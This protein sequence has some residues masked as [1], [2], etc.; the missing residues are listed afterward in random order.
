MRSRRGFTLVEL[1]VVILIVSILVAVAIPIIQGNISAS[2]WSEGKTMMGIIATSIRAY[3]S[4]S[5]PPG[6]PTSL[7]ISEPNNLGFARGDLTG[8]FFD[9]DDFEFEVTSVYPLEYTIIA[10]KSGLLPEQYQLD[11]DGIWTRNP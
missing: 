10:T 9:D 8:A 2:K 4:Q 7:W 11:E 3:F 5:S 1:M 6:P